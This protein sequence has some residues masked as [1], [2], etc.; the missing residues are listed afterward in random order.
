MA[1]LTQWLECGSYDWCCISFFISFNMFVQEEGVEAD[2]NVLE[3][4]EDNKYLNDCLIF[5]YFTMIY[6]QK[7]RRIYSCSLSYLLHDLLHFSLEKCSL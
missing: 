3:V 4:V 6:K 7:S 1:R 5:Y 2:C